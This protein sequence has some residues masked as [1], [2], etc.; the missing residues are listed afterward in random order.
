MWYFLMKVPPKAGTALANQAAGAFVSC[1]I[2]FR[3]KDGAEHLAKY[4]LDEEGWD[5]EETQ[6]AV[7]VERETYEKNPEGL[8][9]FLEAQTDSACFVINQWPVNR[10]DEA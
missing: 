6:E 4:Y 10:E 1:W 7:W 9:H 2:D 8:E 5:H 3:E